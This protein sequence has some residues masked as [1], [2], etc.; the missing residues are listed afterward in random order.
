MELELTNNQRKLI[1]KELGF[2]QIKIND[3]RDKQKNGTYVNGW[4]IIGAEDEI[5][6][7]KKIL[8][9]NKIQI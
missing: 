9:E 5:A 2:Q 7:L 3:L 1:E 8:T 6:T 4:D